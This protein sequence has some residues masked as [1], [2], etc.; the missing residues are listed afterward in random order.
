MSSAIT[1]EFEPS[2]SLG[3]WKIF[4]KENGLIYAPRVIGQNAFYK[5]DIQVL[6]GRANFDALP[7]SEKGIDFTKAE[8]YGTAEEIVVS[9]YWMGNLRGVSELA[10]VIAIE[11]K[12]KYTH[13]DMELRDMLNMNGKKE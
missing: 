4:C 6:F 3:E 11:F 13:T 1:M 5:D 2:V 12:P 10:S 7:A 8:P 9:T